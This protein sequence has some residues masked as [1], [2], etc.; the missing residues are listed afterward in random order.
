MIDPFADAPAD[1]AQTEA[2]EE[3]F[4][5]PPTEAPAPAPAPAPAKKA[6]PKKAAGTV[7]VDV[8]PNLLPLDNGKVSL[9]FKGGT[10]FDAP[11]VV[12]HASDLGDALEQVSGDN[13]AT[14][15]KLMERVQ[16]AG[17]HFTKVAPT[18]PAASGAT[19]PSAAP[20][21]RQAAPQAAQEAPGGEKRFCSHGEMNF[22][23][24]VSKA[25]KPY[26]AYFCSSRDRNDECKA[27]FLR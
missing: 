26:Q 11:W 6:A 1:E 23:S 25:G 7:S 22:R 12:I 3:V 17:A 14:L 21:Q 27:Q 4:A 9:T 8:K 16:R 10:G 13:G 15:A 18:R 5:A 19:A 20:A 24:G 2:P